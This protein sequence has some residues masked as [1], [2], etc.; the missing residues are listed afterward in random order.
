MSL[1]RP[2]YQN[3]YLPSSPHIYPQRYQ[4]NYC[5]KQDK[6]VFYGHFFFSLSGVSSMCRQI[7]PLAGPLASCCR[8]RR[9]FFVLFVCFFP[10]LLILPALE[11]KQT[12]KH[13]W[14]KG[15]EKSKFIEIGSFLTCTSPF[16][17]YQKRCK[18]IG[19][20]LSTTTYVAIKGQPYL[21]EGHKPDV[22][23]PNSFGLSALITRKKTS[24]KLKCMRLEWAGYV[25]FTVSWQED[26]R[27]TMSRGTSFN[28]SNKT[29]S[30]ACKTESEQK[31]LFL[32]AALQH[33]RDVKRIFV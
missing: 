6:E 24:C 22:G 23:R 21:L 17:S 9:R 32:T 30:G 4:E 29:F 14:K 18:W 7:K 13:F 25:G 20:T 3:N 15:R 1:L 10:L 27:L 28:K 19:T 33:F 26:Y 12:N 5:T 16:M 11:R 31:V 2:L 8:R